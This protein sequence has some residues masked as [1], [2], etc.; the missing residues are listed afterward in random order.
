MWPQE[1]AW[2][3]VESAWPLARSS[4]SRAAPVITGR[5]VLDARATSVTGEENTDFSVAFTLKPEAAQRFGQWTGANLN[6]YIAIVLNGRARSAPYVRGP[7]TD[8]G[9][10]PASTRGSRLRTSR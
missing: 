5:D 8:N 4:R 10:I 6:R 1:R 2:P 9:Q 7:I 3:Q